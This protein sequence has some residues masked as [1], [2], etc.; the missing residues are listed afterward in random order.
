MIPPQEFQIPDLRKPRRGHPGTPEQYPGA[1]VSI[2]MVP[3]QLQHVR[4]VWSRKQMSSDE[5]LRGR[6][7]IAGLLV[8]A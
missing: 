7:A 8:M 6:E 4:V 5:R 1:F 3:G 2:S